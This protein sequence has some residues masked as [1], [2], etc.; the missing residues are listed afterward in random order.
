MCGWRNDDGFNGHW[1]IIEHIAKYGS[2][3]KGELFAH[4]TRTSLNFRAPRSVPLP[5]AY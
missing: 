4:K 2:V 5:L 1:T 3:L